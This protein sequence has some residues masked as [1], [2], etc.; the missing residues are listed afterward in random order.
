VGI[1]E[2]ANSMC[3]ETLKYSVFGISISQALLER[4]KQRA[5]EIGVIIT[6]IVII[7]LFILINRVSV[8]K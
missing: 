1:S 6:F 8:L 5:S 7:Y 2:V 3:H 4:I